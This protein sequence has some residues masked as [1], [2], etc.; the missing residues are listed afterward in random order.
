MDI[1]IP[2]R[3]MGFGCWSGAMFW[4]SL[5]VISLEKIGFPFWRIA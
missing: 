2:L 4:A 1:L 3:V 5:G